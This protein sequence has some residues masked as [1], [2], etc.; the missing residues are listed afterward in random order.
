LNKRYFFHVVGDGHT[1]E[2]KTGTNLSG[3]EAAGLQAT[4]IAA[5]LAT[6]P[7]C[8]GLMVYVVDDDG[9]EVVRRTVVIDRGSVI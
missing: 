9:K 5:E 1:H 4:V 2:D 8:Q 7:D 6:D 3:P